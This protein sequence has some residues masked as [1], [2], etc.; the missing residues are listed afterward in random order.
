[1]PCSENETLYDLVHLMF[2]EKDVG[3][4][5]ERRHP[6]MQLLNKLALLDI[7]RLFNLL[8]VARRCPVC[9]S[10]TRSGAKHLT[11]DYS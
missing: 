11:F 10:V 2:T 3:R 4:K 9:A 1:M 6:R 7:Q 5:V 8:H